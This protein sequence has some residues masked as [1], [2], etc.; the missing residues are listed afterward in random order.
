MTV[1]PI[2]VYG[3]PRLE[4]PNA[5]VELFDG[6]LARIVEDLFETGWRAPG[7]GLAAPQIGVNLRLATVDLSVGKDP[8]QRIVLANPGIIETTGR[9][10]VEEGCLSFPGLFTTLP[11]PREV[12]VRAQGLTG[13]WFE[14]AASGLLAQA[15]CHEVD[16]LD[17]RLLVHHLRGIKKKMFLRRVDKMRRSGAW[18]V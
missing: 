7:L 11:R 3:D 2:L 14:L 12:V 13:E 9:A 8:E 1:R 16:H 4:A 15:V 18:A 10:S 17:G 6:E 5:P